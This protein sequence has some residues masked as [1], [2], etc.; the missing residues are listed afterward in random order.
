MLSAVKAMK[1]STASLAQSGIM[2]VLKTV[3]GALATDP[4]RHKVLFLVSDGLENSDVRSFYAHGTVRNI[5]PSAEIRKAGAAGPFW[6]LWG[7][8]CMCWGAL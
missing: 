4:A 8:T 3:S 5:D 6:Q 2:M 1:D 7:R